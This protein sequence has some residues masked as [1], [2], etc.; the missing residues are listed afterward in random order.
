MRVLVT[1]SA[2]HLGEALLRDAPHRGHDAV[3]LDTKPSQFTTHVGSITDRELVKSAL[4]GID[5][6]IHCATLHKPHMATHSKQ[7]FIDVNVGGTLNLLEAAVDASVQA[8]VFTSTTSVFGDSMT[9]NADDAAIWVDEALQPR[10]KNIYGVSKLAAENLC[11][12]FARNHDLPAL[13]LRTSRFFLEEDDDRQR[14]ERYEQANLQ[15]NELLYRRGD[16][17]DMVSAH[18]AA[19]ERANEIGFETLIVTA[20]TPFER[21]DTQ[22]LAGQ[23]PEAVARY[24]P[25]YQQIYQRKQWQMDRYI[26]RVYDNSRAR[27]VLS[28]EPQYNFTAALERLKVDQDHRSDLARAVGKKR[29][30]DEIFSDGPYPVDECA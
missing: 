4:H 9:S 7:E 20:T 28:W 19:L 1:G 8:F 21:A 23:A 27:R 25:E 10:C 13:V 16:I 30:H 12:I 29:Y 17:A 22:L 18:W 2:G 5:A 24:F 11:G 6:V 3:G 26:G 15:V 14:R